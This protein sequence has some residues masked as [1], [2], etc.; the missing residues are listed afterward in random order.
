[1]CFFPL[2][3]VHCQLIRLFAR[4]IEE[5]EEGEEHDEQQQQGGLLKDSCTL[6]VPEQSLH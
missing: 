1:M 6:S 4:G 2:C 3:S 5:E